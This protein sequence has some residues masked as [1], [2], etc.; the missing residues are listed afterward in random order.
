MATMR[1]ELQ[2]ELSPLRYY[3]S[4]IKSFGANILS[5]GASVER[6]RPPEY[7]RIKR[8]IKQIA[9]STEKD[10]VIFISQ[11]ESE[12][13]DD[14]G[15]L[16]KIH[17]INHGA[18]LVTGGFQRCERENSDEFEIGRLSI[19]QT[20]ELIN[21]S[22]KQVTDKEVEKIHST[23]DGN[24]V[25][26]EIA[27]ESSDL[28]TPLSGRQLER[29]WSEV[30]DDKITGRELDLLLGGSHLID[31]HY[32]DVSNTVE[33]TAGECKELLQNLA[34]KGVVSE[35]RSRVYTTDKY[36][37]RY[38]QKEISDEEF[39]EHHRDA[40]RNY[41]G[42]WIDTYVTEMEDVP[43]NPEEV[44]DDEF[45]VDEPAFQYS[46]PDLALAIHHLS[47]IYRDINVGKFVSE[48]N[49]LDG[50]T[51]AVF[52]FGIIAQKYFFENPQEPISK[53]A[54]TIL[55]IDDKT[56]IEFISGT[57][58]II[59]N[60]NIRE[61]VSQLSEGWSGK[62]DTSEIELGNISSPRDKVRKVQENIDSELYDTFPA[63]VRRAIAQVPILLF[64]HNRPARDFYNRFGKTAEKYGLDEPAFTSFLS[65]VTEL[66]DIM[67]VTVD[68]SNGTSN[69]PIKNELQGLN[70]EIRNRIELEQQLKQ[71]HSEA[72]EEFQQ[73]MTKIRNKKEDIVRQY[74]NCG[75]ELEKTP[76]NIFPY[77]WYAIGEKVFTEIFL[78]KKSGDIHGKY[79]YWLA[80]RENQEEG[81]SDE[82][83]VITHEQVESIFE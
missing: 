24:P 82:E 41:A 74:I 44:G 50:D 26:L 18:T 20:A 37:V 61:V 80:K 9:N 54:D 19:E 3:T 60:L 28:Y 67:D 6:E 46:D 36:V 72:Q 35:E 7:V 51:S 40:F 71:N 10:L 39:R 62:I 81:M 55:G 76:N 48:L 57:F 43:D 64:A 13:I 16:S 83:I 65:E 15:W 70:S 12:L 31:L 22:G 78:E 23:H 53:M 42:N 68:S 29:L 25:A 34:N 69:E 17:D 14:F 58:D 45:F 2:R 52:V 30:Y 27:L 5:I 32:R 75:D 33:M 66:I 73:R 21:K 1:W 38:V 4:R 63:E 8:Y 56:E 47:Q 49:G 79:M 11:P 77:L 59:F